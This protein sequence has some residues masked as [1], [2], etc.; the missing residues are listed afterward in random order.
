MCTAYSCKIK[1][2]LVK[3]AL[4]QMDV[5][6]IFFSCCSLYAFV[7]MWSS[8]LLYFIATQH[9]KQLTRYGSYGWIRKGWNDRLSEKTIFPLV[10]RFLTLACMCLH[11]FLT[12]HTPTVV[13]RQTPS[14]W[15]KVKNCR[16]TSV[17]A[18]KTIYNPFLRYML[19]ILRN[20]M[21]CTYRLT[22]WLK[23]WLLTEHNLH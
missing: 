6:E 21:T 22:D 18:T 1:L 4:T 3:L 10:R 14:F 5:T 16:P 7:S 11:N 2:H 19:S 12:S 8:H 15:K 13:V 20:E 9:T 23:K 17:M